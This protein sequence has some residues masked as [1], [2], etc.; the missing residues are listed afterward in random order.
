MKPTLDRSLIG[1]EPLLEI[2]ETGFF[3]APLA[4]CIPL[5]ILL[6][7]PPGS[8]KS[9]A[10]L[11]YASPNIHKTNDVTSAGLGELMEDDKESK[12]RHIIIPD[13]NIVVSHKSSTA[14][15]T[16]ASLLTL[17]SEGILRI[18]DGRRKKEIIHSPVGILTAMTREIYEEHAVRF[19]KLGI[20]R[21][22]I[23]VFFTYGIRTRE[24]IQKSI[25]SGKTTLQQLQ[26][27]KI[28]LPD[29][30]RWPIKIEIPSSA[31]DRI[32]RLSREMAE[33]LSFHPHWE[34]SFNGGAGSNES[35]K[36]VPFRG[37]TPIEFTPHMILR[38]MAQA[39]ALRAGRRVVKESDTDFLIQFINFCNYSN[40]VQL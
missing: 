31:S 23:P 24:L 6:I 29:Q 22:F 37:A 17:M 38:A 5:S 21:R 2:V 11:Q 19:R 13:F 36:I 14:N 8:G 26:E 25:S 30:K 39:H 15:F 35:W 32:E 4:D 40:P 3:T 16:I 12:L 9:K 28:F 33:H 27:K 1:M 10:I 18:D 7:G 34:K 20:S